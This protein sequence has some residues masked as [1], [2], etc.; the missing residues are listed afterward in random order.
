MR[1]SRRDPEGNRGQDPTLVNHKVF[2]SN[3]VPDPLKNLK[4]IKQ[5]FNV[6]L[7]QP[8]SEAQFCWGPMMAC[9]QWYLDSLSP[10]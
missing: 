10:H 3:T 1:G 6:G 4:A 7:Y 2:L 9:F 5:V 8:T